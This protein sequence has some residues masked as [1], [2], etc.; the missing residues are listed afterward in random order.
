MS[1]KRGEGYWL[2]RR[3]FASTTNRLIVN[4][5]YLA[6]CVPLVSSISLKNKA[7]SEE[8]LIK[9]MAPT[10]IR[11]PYRHKVEIADMGV[12]KGGE[13]GNRDVDGKRRMGKRQG[14]CLLYHYECPSS[15]PL[16]LLFFLRFKVR[17]AVTGQYGARAIWQSIGR[18]GLIC[19]SR[20]LHTQKK[21]AH[22]WFEP[23]AQ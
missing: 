8:I 12:K 4:R 9:A 6:E 15:L 2:I 10:K 3:M 13:K 14:L 5:R 21:T 19:I 20:R 11:G 16:R 22:L 1:K 18:M 7:I 17:T 23:N